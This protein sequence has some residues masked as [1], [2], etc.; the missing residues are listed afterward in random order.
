MGKKVKK[1][2]STSVNAVAYRTGT[3]VK[4]VVAE[5][6][7]N[8]GRSRNGSASDYRTVRNIAQ[9]GNETGF[10]T[11]G[12]LTL[13][14]KMYNRIVGEGKRLSWKNLAG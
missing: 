9:F 1:N 13:L 2:K 3:R 5:L 10:V 6:L 4:A 8:T 14:G 12:Q 11:H 7:D